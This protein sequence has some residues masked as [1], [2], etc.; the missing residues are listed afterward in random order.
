MITSSREVWIVNI[1]IHK[2]YIFKRE[3]T[4]AFNPLGTYWKKVEGDMKQMDAFDDDI[5]AINNKNNIYKKNCIKK[6]MDVNSDGES[7]PMIKFVGRN[8]KG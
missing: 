4:T 6:S 8:I 1:G 2:N 3:G 7:I 5:W